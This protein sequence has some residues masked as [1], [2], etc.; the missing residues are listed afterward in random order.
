MTDAIPVSA[1]F[2]SALAGYQRSELAEAYGVVARGRQDCANHLKE[3]KFA[4]EYIQR[5]C[6]EAAHA[7][8]AS[9]EEDC[10][11]PIEAMTLAAL[12]FADWAPFNTIPAQICRPRQPVPKGDV[13]ICPQ[14]N[15][16]HYRL[17]FLVMGRRLGRQPAW[18]NVECDGDEF[19]NTNMDQWNR[20][21]ARDVYVMSCGMSVIRLPG[22]RIFHDPYG[23]AKDV[24]DNLRE[25]S[26]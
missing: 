8:T 6:N 26:E 18:L 12:V 25:L 22:K 7:A 11:S 17:D 9:M 23:C 16:A 21:Q 24:A 5:I 4:D 13:I 19:H 2:A 20:D 3:H 10:E 14:F 1:A 15:F